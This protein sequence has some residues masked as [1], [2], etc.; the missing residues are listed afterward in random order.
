M[1]IH[2]ESA[3][4]RKEEGVGTVGQVRFRVEGHPKPYEVTLFSRK[5]DDWEYGLHFAEESGSE[6]LIDRVEEYLE[7][8]DDAFRMLVNAA[9]AAI[10]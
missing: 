4:G 1:I 8:N 6:E 7:E 9:L 2:I 10:R 3:E 5:G